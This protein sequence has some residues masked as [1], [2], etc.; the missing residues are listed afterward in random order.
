VPDGFL[1][2]GLI[3]KSSLALQGTELASMIVVAKT[4]TDNMGGVGGVSAH[5]GSGTDR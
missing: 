4:R 3:S 5:D 2:L 1:D